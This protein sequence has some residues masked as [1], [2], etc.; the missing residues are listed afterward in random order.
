MQQK[1]LIQS[2]TPIYALV[3]IGFILISGVANRVISV[4]SLEPSLNCRHTIIID[5][6]HGGEDGGA[7]S[8][9]GVLESKFNLEIALRLD[10]MMHLLGLQTIMIR[11]TDRSVYREGE[12]IA[13]KKVSDLKERVRI[14][15][16]TDNALLLSIHQNTFPDGKYWGAQVFYGNTYGSKE[17]AYMM[18]TQLQISLMPSNKRKA[19]PSSGVYLME[20]IHCTGILLECGFLSNHQEE[21]KL[22]DV[23]YQKQL[24]GVI[25]SVYSQYLIKLQEQEVL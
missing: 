15:N 5:P 18:Q 7:T 13:Q 22:R 4:V 14:I 20:N 16:E 21:A 2:L 8:C 3:L 12:T 17:L 24:S 19:K 9:T 6:G 25:A 23:E 1:K 11:E 10:D